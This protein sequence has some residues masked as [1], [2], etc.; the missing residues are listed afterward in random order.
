MVKRLGLE[1]SVTLLGEMPDPYG[2]L[3]AVDVLLIPSFSEAAPMVIGEAA[4]LGTPVL[5][6]R[7]SS[8]EEMIVRPGY[9]WVCDNTQAG[10]TEG[11]GRLLANPKILRDQRE[12]M[13]QMVFTNSDAI[14][15]FRHLIS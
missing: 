11:L 8:A 4:S 9:G 1:A 6:T 13:K 5:S 3:K 12:S 14:D 7:T 10:I 2:Y 15:G